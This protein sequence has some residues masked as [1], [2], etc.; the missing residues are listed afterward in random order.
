MNRR[1]RKRKGEE[2]KKK[3]KLLCWKDETK[4]IE[5]PGECRVL[6]AGKKRDTRSLYFILGVKMRAAHP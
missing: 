5:W 6:N 3:K 1:R 4:G 2:R